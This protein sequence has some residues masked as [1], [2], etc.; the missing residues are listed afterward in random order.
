MAWSELASKLPRDGTIIGLGDG[1]LI[2]NQL[3]GARPTDVD[4]SAWSYLGS[5]STVGIVYI[6]NQT[7]LDRRGIQTLTDHL[8]PQG[9]ELVIGEAPGPTLLASKVVDPSPVRVFDAA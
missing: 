2:L 6:S 9:R 3:I 5:I 8:G 1:S 4:M 7:A